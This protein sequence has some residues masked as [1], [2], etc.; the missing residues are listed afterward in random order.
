MRRLDAYPYAGHSALIGRHPRPWQETGS[1]L[2]RFAA[3]TGRA[4]VRYRAFV[5]EGVAGGRRPELM[6]GGLMRS[7]GGWAIVRELR[8]G[9]E[10]YMADERVL[11][12]S[13]FVESLLREVEAAEFLRRA[14]NEKVPD[15]ATLTRK[16]AQAARVA[17]EA[18]V[19]GGRRREISRARDGL[20]YLWV[21]ALGRSGRQLAQHL[22]V[23][24]E[25][26]YKGARR[27]GEEH[28]LWRNA[29]GL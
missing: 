6:G 10:A 25:S 12:K 17:Q 26:V 8:R 11:G 2:Q 19:G 20:A 16:V 7:T 5:A 23:R 1:V 21:E 28:A 4:R 29:A 9:R 3:R 14:A 24:P 18:L 22:R 13:E 27:G 15:L